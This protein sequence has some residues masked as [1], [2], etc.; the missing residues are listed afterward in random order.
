M[1]L[2]PDRLPPSPLVAPDIPLSEFYDRILRDPATR[3]GGT[4]YDRSHFDAEGSRWIYRARRYGAK[5][6]ADRNP[7]EGPTS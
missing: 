6:Y 4:V 1:A 7:E 5:V 2:G 3:I